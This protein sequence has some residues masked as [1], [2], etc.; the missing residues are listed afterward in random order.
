M[1]ITATQK[2]YNL[3]DKMRNGLHAVKNSL[4]HDEIDKLMKENKRFKDA[5]KGERCFVVG[6]GPSI[7][8]QDLSMLRNEL[9][10]TVNQIT[11]NP[12]YPLLYSNY[13]MWTDV[14]FFLEK[15]KEGDEQLL[16]A[17][18][19]VRTDNNNPE[20]FFVSDALEYIKSHKL[21]EY[22]Q[23]NYVKYDYA[24]NESYNRD[25]DFTGILPVLSTVVHYGIALAVYMGCSEIYLL[26]CDCTSIITHIETLEGKTISGYC[27]DVDETE[28]KR[29]QNM[30]EFDDN[31]STFQGMAEQFRGYKILKEYCEQR[32]IK[33]KNS[34]AGGILN[35]LERIPLEEVLETVSI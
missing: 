1:N 31:Q 4:H 27:Y 34:S 7:K 22:L 32:G 25:F 6:N 19:G 24:F 2:G 30:H 14:G 29:M 3:I 33:L 35:E 11:R 23:V 18:K 12:I 15:G 20:C 5:H 9:V 26:G 13:H 21:D 16:D 28:K 17:I 10:I 8:K